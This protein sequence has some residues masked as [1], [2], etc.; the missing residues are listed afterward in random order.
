MK[1]AWNLVVDFDGCTG[2]EDARNRLIDYIIAKTEVNLEKIDEV[3]IIIGSTRSM[4]LYYD[5][6]ASHLHNLRGNPHKSCAVLGG[7]FIAQL[8]Q[9]MSEKLNDTVRVSFNDIMIADLLNNLELG[10][11]YNLMK[12]Y[13]KNYSEWSK[14]ENSI[15]VKEENKEYLTI[16]P[17]NPTSTNPSRINYKT[18]MRSLYD[19]HKLLMLYTIMQYLKIQHPQKPQLI[20]F[21]D[22]RHDILSNLNNFFS[23][24]PTLVPNNMTL[25]LKQHCIAGHQQPQFSMKN[26]IIGTGENQQNYQHLTQ[27]IAN[28]F[29]LYLQQAPW[30]SERTDSLSDIMVNV[31]K[32]STK[33]RV[34][35]SPRLKFFN[36]KTS[37][38]NDNQQENKKQRVIRSPIT[39]TRCVLLVLITIYFVRLLAYNLSTFHATEFNK[40]ANRHFTF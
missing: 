40:H 21:V 7:D 14:G 29:N 36:E 4:G 30:D 11:H 38:Q 25:V 8:Q 22:D 23:G 35:V 13:A 12:K 5:F 32:Q 15:S 39:D 16:A 17:K 10:T 6:M 9:K 37:V 1:A 18:N 2:T 34:Y 19:E 31:I 27:A 20:S 26:N 24:N 3:C 28:E 33:N